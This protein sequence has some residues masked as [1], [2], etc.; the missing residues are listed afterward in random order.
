MLKCTEGLNDPID[1]Y[2]YTV[3]IFKMKKSM[4]LRN[5]GNF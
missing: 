2:R 3:L 5:V 1:A 4:F